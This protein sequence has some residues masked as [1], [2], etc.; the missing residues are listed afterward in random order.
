MA[1]L[2]NTA[3]AK[4][5]RAYVRQLDD[6]VQHDKPMLNAALQAIEDWFEDNR[7]GIATA[8]NTATSPTVLTG[9]EKKA[10]VKAFLQF[11]LD[12][13]AA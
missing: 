2:T 7:S 5:R 12:R 11:K 4:H 3:L 13:E 8:I 10:L 6:V 9:P 1:T